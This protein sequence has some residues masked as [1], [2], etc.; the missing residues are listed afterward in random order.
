MEGINFDFQLE[1]VELR[2]EFFVRTKIHEMSENAG[3]KGSDL[4]E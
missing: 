1:W 2:S 3:Q 4:N